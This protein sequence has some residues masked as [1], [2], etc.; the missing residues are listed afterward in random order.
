MKTP[1]TNDWIA[2]DAL[3]PEDEDAELRDHVSVSIDAGGA[4]ATLE[5]M[6]AFDA[7]RDAGAVHVAGASLLHVER[8]DKEWHGS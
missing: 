5:L 1:Y 3:G 8:C 6:Q 2:L 4:S 7:M